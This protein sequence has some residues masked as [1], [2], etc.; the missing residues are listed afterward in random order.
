LRLPPPAAGDRVVVFRT[1]K[2]GDL[3]VSSPVFA[4]IRQSRPDAYVVLVASPYNAPVLAGLPG[5]DEIVVYDAGWGF[6][7]KLAFL[8]RLRALRP[9]TTLVLS[10][11]MSGFFYA[12][13]SG[14]KRRG[15]LLKSYRLLPRLLAPLLLSAQETIGRDQAGWRH[16][17]EAILAL[18]AKLGY[19]PTA[20][21]GLGVPDD[22]AARGRMAALL[23]AGAP[24]IAIH[25]GGCWAAGGIDA[26]GLLDLLRQFCARWPGASIVLTGGV[27]ERALVQALA[28]TLRGAGALP[29]VQMFSD[30][31]FAEWSAVLGAADLVVTPDCGA[32]HLAAAHGKPVVVIYA[33]GRQQRFVVEFGP[34]RVKFRALA[35]PLPGPLAAHVL[36]AV[37]ALLAEQAFSA[38]IADG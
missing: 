11:R 5:L 32:V 38:D 17:S 10:P 34:W 22:A 19:R 35:L 37:A 4:A 9:T 16:Q 28:P 30:L 3:L 26:A 21:A 6:R 31:S 27:A 1:D 14:A 29:G 33:P 13:L 23:M 7:A 20:A 8:W 36:D 15:A 2:I 24:R 18:A 25:L 12:L